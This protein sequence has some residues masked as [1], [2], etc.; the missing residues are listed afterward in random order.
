MPDEPWD[1]DTWDK[2]TLAIKEKTNRKGKELF[3]PL[4]EAV[5]GVSQGPEMKK[6]IQ[7][8]GRSKIIERV[9]L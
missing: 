4:R 3:M 2:W 7:L 1:E 5:T 6:L 9:K 8:I